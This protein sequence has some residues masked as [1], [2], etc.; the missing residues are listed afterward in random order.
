MSKFPNI[1]TLQNVYYFFK[2]ISEFTIVK[3][4]QK[5]LLFSKISKFW[6]TILS[7]WNRIPYNLD[8]QK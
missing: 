5:V 2:K 4:L 1:K 7:K 6:E 8:K 3:S